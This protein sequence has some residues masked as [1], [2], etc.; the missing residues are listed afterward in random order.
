MA[1]P[2]TIYDDR[3]YDSGPNIHACVN[4]VYTGVS[5][6]ADIEK[7]YLQ[8]ILHEDD[9]IYQRILWRQNNEVKIFKLNRLIWRV[10]IAL[11]DNMHN[12]KT[13]RRWM[14]RVSAEQL[15][16]YLYVDDL[17]T[18]TNIDKAR[19]LRDKI[20]A[21]LSRSEFNIRQWASN[22]RRIIDDLNPTH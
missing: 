1:T 9:R 8:I 19:A 20:I 7:M 10:F 21:L 5:C 22:D 14:P 15:I 13:C 6:T 4:F 3:T 16:N 18:R 11:S 2:L 17:L 12:P